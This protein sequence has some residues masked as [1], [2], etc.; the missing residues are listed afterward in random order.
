M[1][2]LRGL[3]KNRLAY[4]IVAVLLLGLFPVLPT[5]AKSMLTQILIFGIFAM[6]LNLLVGYTGLFS[7]GH[8]AFF[9]I[10]GYTAAIFITKLGITSFWVVAPTAI[11]VTGLFAAV[12]GVI[13]L[14]V[15][16]I[17][18]LFITMALGEVMAGVALKWQSVTNG[19]NGII[20]IGLPDLNLPWDM[21]TNSFYYF[22]IAILALTGFL[23][24]RLVKSP[25]GQAIQGIREDERL[26]QHL[27]YNTWLYKYT[28]FIISAMLTG[29]AGVLYGYFSGIFV[30]SYLNVE[31]STMAALMVIIGGSSMLFGPLLGAGL[32]LFL[33]Y[34]TSIFAQARWPLILGV[35]FVLSVVFLK[36]GVSVYLVKISERI[37]GRYG[38]SRS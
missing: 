25:F 12:F 27:G 1:G 19:A 29:V 10:G 32:I 8:A 11:I 31:M 36:Q 5:Y 28:I 7:L 2:V 26:M 13:V 38:S 4:I 20:G 34:Y 33:Q 3:I 15:S 18:F 24:S 23:L 16:G 14:R 35:V 17:Y 9:G 37:V 6:S 21:D 22:V 30:P